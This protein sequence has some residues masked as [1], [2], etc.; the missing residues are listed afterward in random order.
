MALPIAAAAALTKSG[1][2]LQEQVPLSK[3]TWWRVGGPADGFAGLNTEEQLIAVQQIAAQHELDVFVL[4]N[5]SNLLI[6][7]EGIRGLVVRLQGEL[8]QCTVA[9]SSQ[10]PVLE[11]GGGLKLTVLL[12]RAAKHGWTGIGCFAGIPGTI[13]GAVRMNAGTSIGETCDPLIDVD[14]ILRGGERQSLTT[15]QLRMSYRT[16]HLPPGSIV[17]QARLATSATD[18]AL[19]RALIQRHLEHRKNTQPLELPSCGSTFRNPPGDTAGRLIEAAGLKGWTIGK[20]QVSTKHANFIVN[21]GG[22]TAGDLRRVIEGVQERVKDHSGIEL[23]RE[24]HFVGD[25]SRWQ[26]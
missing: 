9:E 14:L 8:A 11:V 5:G 16:T 4:G 1:V 18:I 7:E 2:Q 13:G 3:L 12:S 6:S 17:S 25:W 24:V 22:A 23:H 21:L 15:Q 26:G 19:D 20:A 10:P